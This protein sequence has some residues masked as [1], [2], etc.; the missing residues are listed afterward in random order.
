MDSP[1]VS[2]S[3]DHVKRFADVLIAN[4]IFIFGYPRSLGIKDIPQFDYDR[5]LLRRGI[6][7]GKNEKLKTIIIDCPAYGGNSGGIVV[8]VDKQ[9]LS[10]GFLVIGVLSQFVPFAEQW[11]NKAHGYSNVEISNSG[12]SVIVPM[13]MVLELLPEEPKVSGNKK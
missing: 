12:Y 8:E 3:R 2:M 4:E 11:E 10:R 7:A 6:V 9:G 5:P 13:D 1:I